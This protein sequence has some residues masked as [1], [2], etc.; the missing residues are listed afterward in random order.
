MLSGRFQGS[1]PGNELTL[2]V[3]GTPGRLSGTVFNLF[4]T[5]S[6]RYQDRNVRE[7]GIL[8]IE[9]QGR[10]ISAAYIPHFDS[11]VT[12]LS[13]RANRFTSEELRAACNFYFSPRGDGYV[14][15]TRGGIDCVQAIRGATG[16]WTVEVE[17]G[18]IRLRSVKTGE[19]LRFQKAG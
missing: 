17:P 1:T 9:G 19:T 16:K 15:E 14:A 8:R 13:P 6:G 12:A 7:V 10:D 2:D 3:S 4:V 18:S 11:T 5:A